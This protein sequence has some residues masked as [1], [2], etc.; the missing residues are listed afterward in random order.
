M[1]DSWKK[2]QYSDFIYMQRIRNDLNLF[3]DA[4]SKYVFDKNSVEYGSP[5]SPT[6]QILMDELNEYLKPL[7]MRVTKSKERG[8]GYSTFMLFCTKNLRI[9]NNISEYIRDM[10]EYNKINPS[11]NTKISNMLNL[12][13]INNEL[14]NDV[15]D[16]DQEVF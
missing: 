2:V 3:S 13:R 5:E 11:L 8:K 6:V 4:V 10:D 16:I 12:S 9:Y 7:E 1:G 14:T 15:I